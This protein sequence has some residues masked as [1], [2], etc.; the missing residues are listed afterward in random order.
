[1]E[2][3]LGL[4]FYCND[5]DREIT[6]KDYLK[7]LMLTLWK[8]AEGFSGKRPFGNSGWQYDIAACLIKNNIVDGKLDE[9][10]YVDE[11]DFNDVDNVI[12]SCIEKI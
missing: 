6:I 5:L 12:L 8:E 3:V 10:G 4:V 9:D 11:V 7:E 1:M 2:N